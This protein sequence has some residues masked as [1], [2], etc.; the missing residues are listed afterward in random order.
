M[1]DRRSLRFEARP[2]YANLVLT[3]E[4]EPEPAKALPRL[5]RADQTRRRQ[6]LHVWK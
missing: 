3:F 6:M 2:T 4:I 5:R 1:Q